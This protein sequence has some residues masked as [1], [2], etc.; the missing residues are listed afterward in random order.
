MYLDGVSGGMCIAIPMYVYMKM[1]DHLKVTCI[2]FQYVL[3]D[4][5]RY[6]HFGLEYA[7]WSILRCVCLNYLH[8]T[9]IVIW[10]FPLLFVQ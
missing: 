6:L 5:N 10:I 1:M 7:G 2:R 4:S 8:V 9:S 3:G